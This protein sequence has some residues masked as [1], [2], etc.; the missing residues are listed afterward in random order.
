MSKV[1]FA[2]SNFSAGTYLAHFGRV[3]TTKNS[4]KDNTLLLKPKSEM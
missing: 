4:D 3:S 2:G 1:I